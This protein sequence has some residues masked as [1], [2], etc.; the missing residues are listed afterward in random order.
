LKPLIA[1]NKIDLIDD[2]K[3]M[4]TE[5]SI[6]EE[7]GYNTFFISAKEHI[8]LDNLYHNL[9]DHISVVAGN[10]GSGKS[11]LINSIVKDVK[12]PTQEVS[13]KSKRGVHT[14]RHVE[15]I[16]ISKKGYVADTPGFSSIDIENIKSSDLHF[17]FPEFEKYEGRCKFNSCSHTHEPGCKVKK[18]LKNNLI[19]KNRYESYKE[20][21]KEL[22]KKEDDLYG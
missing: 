10:S 7:I 22:Q 6:Y 18:A 5:L 21:Y 17:Y 12:L 14:T 1:F 13:K 2:L 19:S 4:K 3:Q 20:I 11:T 15:M 8:G 16:A 9:E